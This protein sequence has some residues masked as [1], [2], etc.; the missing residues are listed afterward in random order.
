MKTDIDRL[1]RVITT[2]GGRGCGK[3]YAI[4]HLVAGYVEMGNKRIALIIDN[5]HDIIYLRPM[6]YSVFEEHELVVKKL[7]RDTIQVNSSIVKFFVA[8]KNLQERL[9]GVPWLVQSMGKY[10]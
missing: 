6:L 9:R 10:D 2:G 5:L 4:C 7:M 1:H 8:D 3:T